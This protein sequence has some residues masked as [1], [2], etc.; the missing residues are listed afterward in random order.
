MG[1]QGIPQGTL[2]EV[3]NGTSE[4]LGTITFSKCRTGKYFKKKKAFFYQFIYPIAEF[5]EI[6]HPQNRVPTKLEFPKWQR[7]GKLGNTSC[8]I[9]KLFMPVEG[10]DRIED[11]MVFRMVHAFSKFYLWCCWHCRV[12]IGKLNIRNSKLVNNLD[13]F[14]K[15][16]T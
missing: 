14:P 4:R 5:Q 6:W 11:N 12:S 16:H 2:W 3:K 1:L 7:S 9:T 15:V 8:K 10:Y 13:P